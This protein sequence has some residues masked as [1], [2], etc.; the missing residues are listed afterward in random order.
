[1]SKRA[2][3]HI[4]R[5]GELE[6]ALAVTASEIA[7]LVTHAEDDLES[8]ILD[9]GALRGFEVDRVERL[10]GAGRTDKNPVE[11]ITGFTQVALGDFL[12][13]PPAGLR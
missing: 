12:A 10:A 3:Q 5:V 7:L 11:G 9:P 4:D 13:F 6:G 2:G 1:M 8:L